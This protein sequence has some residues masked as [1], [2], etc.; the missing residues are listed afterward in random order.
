MLLGVMRPGEAMQSAKGY[1]LLESFYEH[2]TQ[3]EGSVQYNNSVSCCMYY[4]FDGQ[5]YSHDWG[6]GIYDRKAWDGMEGLSSPYKIGMLLDLDEGILS[7]Y[8]N[9]I[10]LGVMK[11]GLAGHYCWVVSLLAGS[12]IKMKRGTVPAS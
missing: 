3:R 7:V 5:C 12:Q 2:F 9:G 10:K 6:E 4:S 8:K 11:R 1:P